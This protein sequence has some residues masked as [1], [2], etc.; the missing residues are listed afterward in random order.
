MEVPGHHQAA[1][2]LDR[3]AEA[4]GLDLTQDE[5]DALVAY[6]R[7]LPPPGAI[8]PSGPELSSVVEEGRRLFQYTGCAGCHTPDLG[9]IRG[10]YSDLLLHE[11]GPDLSDPG[12]YYDSDEPGSPDAPKGKHWRTPPLW[13]FR[14]SGPYLH[15]G[16]AQTLE[17]AVA[18]HGGQ[19]LDSARRF[20]ALTEVERSLVQ[21]FLRTLVAPTLAGSPE[22]SPAADEQARELVRAADAEAREL[23]RAADAEAREAQRRRTEEATRRATR[24]LSMARTLEEMGKTRGARD[25]YREA[26]REAP[27]SPPGRIAAERIAV[28]EGK[29]PRDP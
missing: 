5:C 25:F 24:K 14:S 3:D 21:A 16:R 22:M 9:P 11:M 6:V 23:V 29:S 19:G 8:E 15:D 2:P 13:G 7:S 4:R 20:R 28:L 26:C 17:E 1:S 10:L 18:R 27:D 12:D